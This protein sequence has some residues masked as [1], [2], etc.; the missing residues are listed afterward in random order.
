MRHEWEDV[1]PKSIAK[2]N[3]EVFVF[4]TRQSEKRQVLEREKKK[5]PMKFFLL[6]IGSSPL[7]TYSS[8]LRYFR[9]ELFWSSTWIARYFKPLFFFYFI[10][11]RLFYSECAGSG[12]EMFFFFQWLQLFIERL[13]VGFFFLNRI[14]VFK[15]KKEKKTYIDLPFSVHIICNH[16]ILNNSFQYFK[17]I[18]KREW[19]IKIIWLAFFFF[20]SIKKKL[21]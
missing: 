5:Q 12:S 19:I 13:I 17:L 9:G 8:K 4:G 3:R 16:F 21:R 14:Y 20:Y 10:R 18:F 1:V 15:K 7:S 6:S 2:N 11:V